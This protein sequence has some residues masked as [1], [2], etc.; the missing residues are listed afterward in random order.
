LTIPFGTPKDI[1]TEIKDRVKV[2]GRYGALVISPS[3]IIGPEVPLENITAFWEACK[4][5]C[6]QGIL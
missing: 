5:Y 1:D 4:K 2:L 6:E 3:N